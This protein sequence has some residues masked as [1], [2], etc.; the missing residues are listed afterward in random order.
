MNKKAFLALMLAI[1]MPVTGY[2]L[3]KYYAERDVQMPRRYFYDDVKI[4]EKDGKI[5]RDTIW[6]SVR[7]I[8]LVNQ[9]GD[10]VN[11]D[12]LKGKVLVIDFFFTHCPT[13]CPGLARSMQRLQ[14]SFKD[15]NDSIVQFLSISIDPV[16]DSVKNLRSFANHY[17]SNHD[18]WWFLTGDKKDIY[19]FALHEI[20][21]NIAD[22]NIDTA[23]VHTP[24]FF[25][26]D[27]DRVVRGWYDGRDSV[28]QAKLVR[29]IPLLMLEKDRKRT[30][31]QFLK[32]LF[33]RS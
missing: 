10:T 2:L 20:K 6:H 9:L 32:E 21:A 22:I 33:Q 16:H 29:D 23:F 8:T 24:M 14:N 5:S 17:T 15:N 27:R 12:D 31:G 18:T 28:E 1:L 25:L 26:L 19:D 7:N 30:F 3:V 13:V 11:L 4:I